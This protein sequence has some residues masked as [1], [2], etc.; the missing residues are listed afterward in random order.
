MA[1][2]VSQSSPSQQP[3]AQEQEEEEEGG[4][5]AYLGLSDIVNDIMSIQVCGRG[6]RLGKP[7]G[8]EEPIL[9]AASVPE[10]PLEEPDP[11]SLLKPRPA[12]KLSPEER[13]A[14]LEAAA[15]GSAAG[16]GAGAASAEVA[17]AGGAAE[18]SPT[19][20]PEKAQQ[21]QEEE[22]DDT[23][24]PS[25]PEPS[26][27]EPE[28]W[29]W[30]RWALN[31]DDP[32][33]QVFVDDTSG[34]GNS[35]WVRAVPMG[36]VVNKSGFD[37][38]LTAQYEWDKDVYEEDFGPE[39]VR[40]VGSKAT[41]RDTIVKS[42]PAAAGKP[43]K[44]APPAAAPSSGIM[45]TAA[46]LDAA[47]VKASVGSFAT[48]VGSTLGD[49]GET[50]YHI[51]GGPISAQ[52]KKKAVV[53]D[54]SKTTKQIFRPV[55]PAQGVGD[56][57]VAK[58]ASPT[59]DTQMG[60]AGSGNSWKWPDFALQYDTPSIEVFLADKILSGKKGWW[61]AAMPKNR[62]VGPN[63]EDVFLSVEYDWDGWAYVEEFGPENVRRVGDQNPIKAS[64]KRLR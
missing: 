32:C 16:A 50:F 3:Q 33:I 4:V 48:A 26:E 12:T 53:V 6:Q 63:G 9:A 17:A 55:I 25:A 43:E 36:R 13:Q 23:T 60:N 52:P 46:S 11:L 35:R 31:S 2:A 57:V 24:P 30:P 39:R 37:E 58:A 40:K 18:A 22:K 7:E 21:A 64:Q 29:E 45:A 14:R 19:D 51:G 41:V 34:S 27:P 47:T 8:A 42:E 61:V 44:A 56:E 10:V 1:A 20:A 49:L 59:G 54:S 38:F 5:L 15:A 28:M 62:V